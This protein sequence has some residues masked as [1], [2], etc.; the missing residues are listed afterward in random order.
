MERLTKLLLVI[1]LMGIVLELLLGPGLLLI[2]GIAILF[3]LWGIQGGM[4]E[5]NPYKRMHYSA[6]PDFVEVGDYMR[7]QDIEERDNADAH[8]TILIFGIAMILIGIDLLVMW[9]KGWL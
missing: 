8:T 3:L 7:K 1:V 4:T 9:G 2:C 6:L 5:G